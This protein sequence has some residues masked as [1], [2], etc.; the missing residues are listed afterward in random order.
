MKKAL[1]WFRRDL[2]LED[3]CALYHCLKDNDSVAPVFI[4]DKNILESLPKKDKRVDFIWHCI[5]NIKQRLNL[6]GSDLIVK[7]ASS[8]EIVQLAKKYKVT[9][10]YCNEDYEPSAVSRDTRVAQELEKN[11]ILFKSFKDTVIFAKTEIVTPQAQ[12]YHVFTHYKNAWRKK[13]EPSHYISYPTLSLI[14]KF[15]KF[16]S[17][18]LI[19]LEDIG[20]EKTELSKTKIIE[21][22]KNAQLLFDRFKKKTIANYKTNRD[23]PSI[24]GTSFLSI[25]HRFGTISI[26]REVRE[27]LN[28]LKTSAGD[29]KESCEGWLN[30]L[31]WRDFYFQILF[32][33]PHVADIPFKKQYIDFPWDNNPLGFSQWCDGKTGYPLVDAAM[34][35]L[36][37]TG[38]MHNRLRM[39]TASFLTKLMLVD[40][41]L[42]E[43]YFATK[44]LDFDLAANNGGWQWSA[45]TGCDAQPAFRIF[46]PMTQSEKF[47]EQA[48]F[49]KKYLPVF[50]KVPPQFIHAPWEHTK[51]L[52]DLGIV[53]G[54]DYPLPIV[55]YTKARQR[56][57]MTFEN[58]NAHAKEENQG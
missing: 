23:F 33:Y 56:A 42:G 7:H 6:I 27:V 11:S 1:F 28:L 3:N 34:I 4:F 22:D 51:E 12:P 36:N 21:G 24:S 8:D 29:K 30:E 48:I 31:I 53:L 25:H 18:I 26:R 54:K 13:I 35:Q 39:L 16:K 40:Y 9:S 57:L 20:F 19:S 5:S 46:N 43:N 2:R 17:T 37:T 50:S 47:D 38:Y 45:S 52:E 14:E 15:A 44:L 55:D 41:R 49:I 10:V 58:F 32:N